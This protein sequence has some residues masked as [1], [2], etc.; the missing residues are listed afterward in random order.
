MIDS[1]CIAMSLKYRLKNSGPST[2][3]C[4]T[5]D[6]ATKAVNIQ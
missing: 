5:P 1:Q 2:D 3:T 6:V 4:D